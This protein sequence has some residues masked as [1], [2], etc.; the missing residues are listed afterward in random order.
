MNEVQ[1]LLHFDARRDLEHRRGSF[2]VTGV[3]MAV[4]LA[5]V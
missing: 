3:G 2:V 4:Y 5:Q 1:R